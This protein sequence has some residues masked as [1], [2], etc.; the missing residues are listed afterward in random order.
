MAEKSPQN[1]EEGFG[2]FSFKKALHRFPGGE[3]GIEK[4][5]GKYETF[6]RGIRTNYRGYVSDGRKTIRVMLASRGN[7]WYLRAKSQKD[8]EKVYRIYQIK[9]TGF[10]DV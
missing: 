2:E 4:F 5:I 1:D 6:G 8:L 3:N 7:L 10:V 9:F